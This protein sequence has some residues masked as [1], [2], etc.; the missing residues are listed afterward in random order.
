MT[1]DVKTVMRCVLI[2]YLAVHVQSNSLTW[3]NCRRWV[4]NSTV[5]R[6]TNM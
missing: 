6:G 2:Y 3:I 5:S 1:T 4:S